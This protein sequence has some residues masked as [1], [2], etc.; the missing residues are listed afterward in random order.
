VYV[1]LAK[2]WTDNVWNVALAG[3]PFGLSVVSINVGKHIDKMKDDRQKGVGTLPVRI[4]ETAARYVNIAILV[5]IY[6]VVVYLVFV[7]CYFT[8]LMLII[9]LAGKRL[10]TSV[11][12]LSKPR[13]ETAPPGY[14]FWPT[15]FS[16]FNF[17]HNRLFGGLFI[18]ALI[19]DTLLRI[20][21]P[22]FW[23]IR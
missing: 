13:P 7:P 1:V 21:L 12:I 18:L 4:G 10:L 17:N 9:F 2:G 8:P 20:F 11:K 14:P 16:A 22:T 5:L 6:L 3:V 23:P 15:W 19:G